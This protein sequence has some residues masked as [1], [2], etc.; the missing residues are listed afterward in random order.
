[1]FVTRT[2]PTPVGDLRLVA[3]D[4]ALVGVWFPDHRGAPAVDA[5][6][7]GTHPLLDRAEAELS[8]YFAGTLR[9][10]SVPTRAAGTPFQRAVWAELARIPYG[11]TRSYAQIAVAVGRPGATRAVGTAN[12]ANPLS[13]VVPCHRVVATGGAISGYAGG[14]DKKRWLLDWEA[15]EGATA[16]RLSAPALF[17]AHR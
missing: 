12:G 17:P 5:T 15:N 16:G 4:T 6:S 11:E 10:F 14:V 2:L 1:M 13:I 7:V 3:D 8:A 9:G